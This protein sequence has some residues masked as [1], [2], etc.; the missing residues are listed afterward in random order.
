MD[1]DTAIR[2]L[3]E[4]ADE[5]RERGVTR[6]QLFGSVARGDQNENSD[7]DILADFDEATRLRLLKIGSIQVRLEEI[8]NVSVDL[9]SPGWLKPRIAAR[10]EKDAVLVF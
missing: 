8:L 2:I 6:L 3:R 4:H 5:L 9:S 7:V 10:A 1:R